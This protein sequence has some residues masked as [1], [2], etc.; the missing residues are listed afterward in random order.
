MWQEVERN[1][2]AGKYII[3]PLDS[4]FV[5]HSILSSPISHI[6]SW[7]RILGANRLW[8]MHGTHAN[9]SPRV[10]SSVG[11][12]KTD[13]GEEGSS[14]ASQ[15][16]AF[17]YFLTRPNS[18]QLTD[19]GRARENTRKKVFQNWVLGS[20]AIL[21]E[22]DGRG[23]FISFAK[24]AKQQIGRRRPPCKG[25]WIPAQSD[26]FVLKMPICITCYNDF[27]PL[28]QQFIMIVGGQEEDF[29]TWWIIAPKQVGKRQRQKN[30]GQ[31]LTIPK[32]ASAQIG[33]AI[34]EC[35]HE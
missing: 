11:G 16:N 17:S 30:I 22:R 21:S 18:R 7:Q 31:L 1:R 4:Q 3:F 20:F 35:L 32:S 24:D 8:T 34:Q 27:S 29:C 33:S 23:V 12:S 9:P 13:D 28:G 2:N 19:G 25:E 14:H 10:K 5:F 26:F 15:K 6:I